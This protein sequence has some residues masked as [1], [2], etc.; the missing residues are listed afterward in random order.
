VA[1]YLEDFGHTVVRSYRKHARF[2][3]GTVDYQWRFILVIAKDKAGA[4][5]VEPT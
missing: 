3:N 4:S 2:R 5:P 1:R